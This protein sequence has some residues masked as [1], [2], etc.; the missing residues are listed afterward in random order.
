MSLSFFKRPSVL[1]LLCVLVCFPKLKATEVEDLLITK[2]SPYTYEET[3]QRADHKA[4]LCGFQLLSS[5][6]YQSPEGEHKSTVFLYQ[7]ERLSAALLKH[8]PLATLVLPFKV[9]I[10]GKDA[11]STWVTYILPTFLDELELVTNEDLLEEVIQEIEH[12]TDE[13]TFAPLLDQ[14]LS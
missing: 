14:A 5:H 12:F 8:H 1:I 6:A 9:I 11:H 2:G 4:Q 10:W 13:I 7:N 3:C